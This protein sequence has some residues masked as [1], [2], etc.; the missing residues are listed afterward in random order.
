MEAEGIIGFALK[1]AKTMLNK[2]GK[3]I[4]RI[5]LAS[6]PKSGPVEIEEY[7]RVINVAKEDEESY[8][9][10]VCKPL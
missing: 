4:G 7:F 9:L 1:D 10:V 6:Q 3:K 2:N 8:V 5:I